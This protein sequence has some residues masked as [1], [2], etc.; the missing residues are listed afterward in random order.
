M[1]I[2]PCSFFGCRGR[3]LDRFDLDRPRENV[4]PESGHDLGGQPERLPLLV[5]R[6]NAQVP[7][8]GLSHRYCE[9]YRG[10]RGPSLRPT[11]LRGGREA[12]RDALRELG[13]LR[14]R[15]VDHRFVLPQLGR[16]RPALSEQI[17]DE[18][19][20]ADVKQLVVKLVAS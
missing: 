5:R 7:G 13:E 8:L 9:M 20:I 15:L 17:A 2:A 3:R 1:S 10:N 4:A 18:D 6:Q 11:V 19:Q 12:R 16:G 14:P